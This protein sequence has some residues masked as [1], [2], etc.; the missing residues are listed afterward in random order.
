[1]PPPPPNSIGSIILYNLYVPFYTI[2]SGI[3]ITLT[4]SHYILF[5]G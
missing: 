5:C 4:G 2:P 1:M 3:L